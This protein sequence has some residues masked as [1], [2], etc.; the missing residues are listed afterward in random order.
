[1]NN[2]SQPIVPKHFE[3]IER[4]NGQKRPFIDTLMEPPLAIMLPIRKYLPI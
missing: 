4:N 2:F 1:M 3:S